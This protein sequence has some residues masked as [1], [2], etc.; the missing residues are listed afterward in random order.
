MG[1]TNFLLAQLDE[2]V[3]KIQTENKSLPTDAMVENLGTL[4]E[5]VDSLRESVD[6]LC[7]RKDENQDC[8]SKLCDLINQNNKKNDPN[9]VEVQKESE[10][11]NAKSK[12]KSDE[13]PVTLSS[14]PAE[15]QLDQFNNKTNS[16][17]EIKYGAPCLPDSNG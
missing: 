11:L 9:L 5:Q 3:K 8:I 4:K 15:N 7:S 14:E 16:N 17:D 10:N 6:K 1:K 13:K 12:E 2:K